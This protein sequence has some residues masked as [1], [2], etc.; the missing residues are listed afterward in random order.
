M[1]IVHTG[2]IHLDTPFSVMNPALSEQRRNDLRTSFSQLVSFAADNGVSL[3][4]IAGDLYESAY[5]TQSTAYFLQKEFAKAPDCRFVISPGNHDPYTKD[6]IYAN[7]EFPDNVYIFTE[8]TL[9]KFSFDDIGVDVYGYAFTQKYSETSPI[10]NQFPSDMGKINLLCAHA[11]ISS[12][13]SKYSPI[14]ANEIA[15]AS[16]DY[17]ALAHIHAG[18]E[19]TKAGNSVYAYCGCLEGRDY[20]ECGYKGALIVDIEKEDTVASVS[21]KAQRFSRKRY[22]CE[23]LSV[24]GAQDSDDIAKAISDCIVKNGYGDD[25]HLRVILEGN[26]NPKLTVSKSRIEALL[27]ELY[28]F[29]LI[30]NTRPLFDAEKLKNDPTIRG[31]FFNSMLEL[32]VSENE[33]DKRIASDALRYGLAAI[34]SENIIDFE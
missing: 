30:D 11:D 10:I 7:T 16:F 8:N 1:K 13:I 22:A 26:I 34:D 17:C 12:A 29:D 24:D 15:S 9:S 28:E 21:V 32:L 18:S 19:P 20:G 4:L 23:H 31:A 5:A 3:V 25:T 6:S 27:R 14:T 33:E 2:D